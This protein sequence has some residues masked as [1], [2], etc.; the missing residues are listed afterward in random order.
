MKKQIVEIIKQMTSLFG[1]MREFK[2]VAAERIESFIKETG[3]Y[4]E[5]LTNGMVPSSE[6]IAALRGIGSALLHFRLEL[7]VPPPK[8]FLEVENSVCDLQS[9]LLDEA[10]GK[11]GNDK[12]EVVK[13]VLEDL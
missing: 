9:S 13:K 11:I 8:C 4:L 5:A 10:L 3:V 1:V 7:S 12:P 2:T 6:K